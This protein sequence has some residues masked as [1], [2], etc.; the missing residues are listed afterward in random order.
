MVGAWE[1]SGVE[2]PYPKPGHAYE[3]GWEHVEFVL[4]GAANTMDGLRQA[5]IE[6]FP[7]L[8]ID[9]LQEACRLFSKTRHLLA[10]TKCRTQPWA[11]ESMVLA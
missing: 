7:N 1:V 9:E 10:V 8:A 3:H 2:V 5:F 4:N 11:L 6:S